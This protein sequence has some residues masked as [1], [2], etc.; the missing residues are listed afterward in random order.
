MQPLK[1]VEDAVASWPGISIHP[2]RF[3]G[4]EFRFAK[5][6][7]GHV[8]DGGIVDIPFPRSVHDALLAEGLAEEHQWV[9]NSGWITFRVRS[10]KDVQRAVW[11]MRFSYFRYALKSDSDS[12]TLFVEATQ[13]LQLTPR[14]KSLLEQFAAKNQDLPE[15]QASARSVSTE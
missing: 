5:G 6:E 14:F 8:H 13:E 10:D 2:H 12:R 9:P 3:G 7:V 1:K 15:P 11:L 4:R